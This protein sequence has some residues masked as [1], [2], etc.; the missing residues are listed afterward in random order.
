MHNVDKTP[1]IFEKGRVMGRRKSSMDLRQ[2]YCWCPHWTVGLC[3]KWKLV[4]RYGA[5]LEMK[6]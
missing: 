4:A 1:K 2:G 5:W 3:A 6:W